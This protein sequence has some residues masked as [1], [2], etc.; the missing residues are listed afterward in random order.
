MAK[1]TVDLINSHVVPARRIKKE[2]GIAHH[3]ESTDVEI[4]IW[5]KDFPTNI[6]E[7]K[8]LQ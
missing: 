3:E 6:N 5:L 8:L 1:T 4:T 2:S 7:F